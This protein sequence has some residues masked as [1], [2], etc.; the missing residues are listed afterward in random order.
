MLQEKLKILPQEPGCYLMKDKGGKIIYIGK[1]KKLKNR[2]KSYF[3]NN[4]SGKTAIM[5]NQIVDFE[6]IV[7]RTEVEALVLELNL[8]KKYNPKYN[9]LFKDDKTY[10]Y[11]GLTNEKIPRLKVFRSLSK[12]KENM[13]LYGPYPSIYSARNMVQL[14]N[15]L[16]PLPKCQKMPKEKCLYYH[17]NECLGYCEYQIDQ[18][19][20][21]NYVGE[22][23]SFL[24]GNQ[25]IIKNKVKKQLNIYNNAMMFE[26]SR[27]LQKALD[28]MESIFTNQFVELK[29]VINV[30]VITAYEANNHIAINH[31]FTRYG[32]VIS[33]QNRLFEKIDDSAEEV[34]NYVY[35]HFNKHKIKPALI[36]SNYDLSL[37]SDLI[38]VETRVPI[39][40]ELKK[41]LDISL[42]N[43]QEHY[44]T[45]IERYVL[46]NLKTNQVWFDLADVLNIENLTR[47]ELFDNA[48]LFGTNAVSGMIAYVNGVKN[49]NSYRKYKIKY[50]ATNDDYA[51]MRE[52]LYRRYSK[53]VLEDLELPD[54][55]IVDGGIGQINIAK[56]V[57]R[58]IGISIKIFG[59]AKDK[60]HLTRSLID[61]SGNIVN[62]ENRQVMNLLTE[63]QKEVHRY[64]I[65]FHEQNRSKK[66]LLSELDQIKG[67]GV[68]R[69]SILYQNFNNLEEMKQADKNQLI[70]LFGKYGTHLYNYW[71]DPK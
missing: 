20:I 44:Q 41:V 48:H 3:K 53:L 28:A 60:K 40:G 8:I 71:H 24:K 47:I 65:S 45:Q 31:L 70:S 19:I 18:S 25:N 67:L 1:A 11:I 6:Y 62:I 55:I 14:I 61:S 56:D 23:K 9:V 22:I 43:A 32:K 51:M 2:V 39:R 57:I 68:K 16:Y 5:V 66:A 34:L 58:E 30:D 50:A 69:K 26:Q 27:D 10:P 35:S 7:T 42:K 29:S 63:M 46:N 64:T 12:E 38:G 33:S 15:R 54:A 17:I 36:I 21:D 59:L 37:I 4:H 13:T 49:R 52:V